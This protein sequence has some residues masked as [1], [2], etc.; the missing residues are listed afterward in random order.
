[1]EHPSRRGETARAAAARL[2]AS[3]ATVLPPLDYSHLAAVI[4]IVEEAG[5]TFSDL[6]RVHEA[7]D[8]LFFPG[9]GPS[10]PAVDGP[11]AAGKRP[12]PPNWRQRSDKPGGQHRE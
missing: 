3:T 7:D 10:T 8:H 2:A 12:W 5:G 1:M 6:I 4:P 11:D 9:S